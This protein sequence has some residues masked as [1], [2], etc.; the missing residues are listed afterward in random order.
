MVG[1][2]LHVYFVWVLVIVEWAIPRPALDDLLVG[3]YAAPDLR[4]APM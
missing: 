2:F 4:L 3:L 1:H